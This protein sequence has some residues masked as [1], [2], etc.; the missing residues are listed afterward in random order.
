MVDSVSTAL[1]AVDGQFGLSVDSVALD[2]QGVIG[3]TEALQ[4]VTLDSTAALIIDNNITATD[5]V[6]LTSAGG[7]TVNTNAQ[8]L[9]DL[10]RF[11][12]NAIISTDLNN[13]AGSLLFSGTTSLGADVTAGLDATFNNTVTLTGVRA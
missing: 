5:L 8:I 4:Y 12:N 11:N 9:A 3:G 10:V 7:I 2:L 1:G 6:D 13:T